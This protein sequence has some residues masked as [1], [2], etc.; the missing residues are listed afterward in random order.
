MKRPNI[1]RLLVAASLVLSSHVFAGVG[2]EGAAGGDGVIVNDKV[3][4]LDL[5]EAG[6][7]EGAWIDVSLKSDPAF[8][9]VKTKL[10]KILANLND[11]QMIE[12]LS[13]KLI[14]LAKREHTL[15]LL[16]VDTIELFTWSK[17]NHALVDVPDDDS[18]LQFRFGQLI[19]VAIRRDK[20]IL[21][22]R[23]AYDKMSPENRAAMVLHEA[24]YALTK[25]TEAGRNGF[26][27]SSPNA[28][29]ICGF[30]FTQEFRVDTD[31]K[32][33]RELKDGYLPPSL[34]FGPDNF[35]TAKGTG[36]AGAV[37]ARYYNGHSMVP[38]MTFRLAS[39]PID[40]NFTTKVCHALYP[41]NVAT[42]LA[43]KGEL[44][45]IDFATFTKPSG[46]K[47]RFVEWFES[48]ETYLWDPAS[49]SCSPKALAEYLN[50]IKAGLGQS[51]FLPKP[52]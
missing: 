45:T 7:E 43:S 34:P 23:M 29:M 32:Q 44:L 10:N 28:R 40:E 22:S 21:V 2:N 15:A 17:V 18:V 46:E 14:E 8:E 51:I 38:T 4:M 33:F 6:V 25:P 1:N 3:Y 48:Y 47:I 13:L 30:L 11:P 5:V 36:F 24:I 26:R 12:V 9:P 49:R 42:Q 35:A 37:S 50:Q 27:Q 39:T 20:A 52:K 19:Q 31:S 16:L 41:S